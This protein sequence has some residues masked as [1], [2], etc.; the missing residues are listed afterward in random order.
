MG[1]TVRIRI[2]TL[3]ADLAHM[4]QSRMALRR[5]SSGLCC[6]RPALAS[7]WIMTVHLYQYLHPNFAG[8]LSINPP[9]AQCVTAACTFIGVCT[10]RCTWGSFIDPNGPEHTFACQDPQMI[11]KTI[12][13]RPWRKSADHDNDRKN[14]HAFGILIWCVH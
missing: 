7:R 4:T 10:N 2:L 13:D 6:M 5:P 8:P 1:S 9:Q 3:L 14:L 11:A 12:Y